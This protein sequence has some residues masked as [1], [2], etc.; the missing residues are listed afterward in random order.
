M[1]L[2]TGSLY[3]QLT[4]KLVAG[5]IS[6]EHGTLMILISCIHTVSSTK[7]KSAQKYLNKLSVN[8]LIYLKNRFLRFLRNEYQVH[9]NTA[10]IFI[11]I[12]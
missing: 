3:L 11:I 8:W 7:E 10:V 9:F 4:F 2:I 6:L 5:S 12:Q 1:Y